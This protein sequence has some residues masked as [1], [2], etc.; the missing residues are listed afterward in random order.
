[1][2]SIITFSILNNFILRVIEKGPNLNIFI[3]QAVQIFLRELMMGNKTTGAWKIWKFAN[4]L[5]ELLPNLK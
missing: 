4:R 1:M 2:T 5:S 3:M